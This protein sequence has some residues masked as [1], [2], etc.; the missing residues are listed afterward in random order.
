[1]GQFASSGSGTEVLRGRVSFA[2]RCLFSWSMK[3]PLAGLAEA[4]LSAAD[5]YG[6]FFLY[7]CPFLPWTGSGARFARAEWACIDCL[8][9]GLH[10]LVQPAFVFERAGRAEAV[11][12]RAL[13]ASAADG[14]RCPFSRR[15]FVPT[16]DKC[17]IGGGCAG[18]GAGHRLAPKSRRLRLALACTDSLG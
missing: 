11:V 1:M 16:G 12:L 14:G 13:L 4:A 7:R 15:A 6:L 10:Q 3:S 17:P 5:V 18:G 9:A 8:A 2:V